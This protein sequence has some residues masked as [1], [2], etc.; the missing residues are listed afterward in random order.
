MKR[1]LPCAPHWRWPHRFSDTLWGKFQ[2]RDP[3]LQDIAA[4][5]TCKLGEH[6]G[7]GR[8]TMAML[9][10]L[11]ESHDLTYTCGCTGRARQSCTVK[12]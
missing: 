5:F 4:R 10:D 11:L 7:V 3:S 8:G 1:D 2:M 6:V 9:A 12:P